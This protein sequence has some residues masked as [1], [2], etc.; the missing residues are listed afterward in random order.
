MTYIWF[1]RVQLYKDTNCEMLLLLYLS[2][3]FQVYR[4]ILKMYALVCLVSKYNTDKVTIE[5]KENQNNVCSII[6]A[7][8][9][10]TMCTLYGNVIRLL[11]D[12]IKVVV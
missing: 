5:N 9:G 10:I 3:E 7:L 2:N 4:S 6:Y 11:H 8:Y 1:Y 12:T